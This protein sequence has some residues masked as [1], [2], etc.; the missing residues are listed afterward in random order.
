M[1]IVVW[2][3]AEKSPNVMRFTHEHRPLECSHW[4]NGMAGRRWHH[5]EP[6]RLYCLLVSAASC[7][8]CRQHNIHYRD[9]SHTLYGVYGY[10]FGVHDVGNS[11]GVR[12]FWLSNNR[13]IMRIRG[14]IV[15]LYMFVVHKNVADW[16]GGDLGVCESAEVSQCVPRN[17]EP[18]SRWVCE[19]K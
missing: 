7:T 8:L 3:T 12:V 17:P 1:E 18:W 6:Y 14:V 9:L 11:R 15:G 16:F 13:I 4:L 5:N 19:W 2:G 10:V